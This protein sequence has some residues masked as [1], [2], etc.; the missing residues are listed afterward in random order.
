MIK[1]TKNYSL[2]IAKAIIVERNKIMFE[3]GFYEKEITPPLGCGI[4]GYFS[5]RRGCDVLD[6]LY[7]RAVVVKENEKK[8]AIISVDGCHPIGRL[9]DEIAKRIENFS[10]ITRE[11]VMVCF[12]HTHTGIPFGRGG[13]PFE[14]DEIVADSIKGYVDVFVRLVADCA[15]LA[16]LRLEKCSASFGKGEVKGI[17]F[18]RDYFM[19]NSTPRTN[20][21]RTSPD[22]EGP[23]TEAD[24][25]L[26][27]L[28]I[29]NESGEPKGAILSFACHADCV[30][31][32]KLTGDYVSIL[33]KELKKVYG[34]D[35]VSVFLLGCCGNINHFD[36]SKESDSPDHYVKMGKKLAGEAIKAVSFAKDLTASGLK[37]SLE[38]MDIPRLEIE[39]EKIEMAKYYIATVK[40]EKGIKLAADGTAPDQYN[41]AMSKRLMNFLESTPDSFRVPLQCIQ[42]GEFTIYGFNSEIFSDFG[43]IVKKGDG[44]GINLVATLCNDAFGYVPTRDMFYDT[45]YE[46]SPGS[47]QMQ[48]DAVYIMA[49]KL[50]SMK[51]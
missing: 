14:N 13:I 3:F 4:P 51:K 34:E 42:I 39:D 37:S 10:G 6:R 17:S 8:V 35:F 28:F 29:K 24:Y 50:I 41:L 16:D 26:P 18:V 36:V 49:E 46:S 22:I 32:E 43:K 48:K 12:T 40:E 19:K 11:N 47:A 25:E 2:R 31:G 38:Y 1:L 20:P 21:P 15:I 30:S 27:V 9:S 44:T 23:V 7:A 5:L 33:S 45:I